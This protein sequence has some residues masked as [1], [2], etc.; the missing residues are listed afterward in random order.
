VRTK[1]LGVAIAAL[2]AAVASGQGP[3]VTQ[4]QNKAAYEGK[5]L[6]GGADAVRV[7]Y[8]THGE[9]PQDSQE[10]VNLI[11]ATADIQ[12]MFPYA[13]RRAIALRGT[14]DQMALAEW[15]FSRLDKPVDP[16]T[17][18]AAAYEFPEPGGGVDA[19]R[20]FYFT[21]EE[22]AENLQEM[23]NL[24]RTTADIQRVFSYGPRR[25]IALRGTPA[26][27]ALAEWLFGELDQAVSPQTNRTDAYE[28]PAP[29]GRGDAVR[30]FFFSH[31]ETQQDLQEI[32]KLIRTTADI[33]RIFSYGPRRAIALRG[34]PAQV[35]LAEWLFGELGTPASEQI[36]P[37]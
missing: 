11:R 36:R 37:K 34:T 7:F 22:T 16:Q 17:A 26:Q 31:G 13:A 18:R 23:I 10:I 24:I 1:T 9:T 20:V 30:L 32:I 4:A 3:A 6:D 8:L 2:V 5:A 15:L 29:G 12:R 35:A 33:Q 21:H 27:I 25:A 28:H 19:V 14:P